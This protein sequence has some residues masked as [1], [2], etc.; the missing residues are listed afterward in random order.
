MNKKIKWKTIVVKTDLIDPSP[1]NYK[2]ANKLGAERLKQSLK[3]FGLAGSVI[4]NPGKK[5]RYV[6]ID[7]NSRLLEAKEDGEKTLNVSIPNRLLTPKEFL[8]M[9]K[10]YDLSKAG[11]VDEARIANDPGT[12][13]DFFKNYNMPIPASRLNAL[14]KGSRVVLDAKGDLAK[15]KKGKESI[16]LR[17][18]FIEPPFSVLDTKQGSWQDRK[19]EWLEWGVVGELGREGDLV[20]IESRDGRQVS[21]KKLTTGI[22]MK[23]YEDMGEYY[24]EEAQQLNTSIFDPALCELMYS[25]FVPKAGNV[26]DPFAGGPSRGLVAQYLG[27]KYYGIELSRRQVNANVEQAKKLLKSNNQPTYY[28]GDSDKL[29]GK[30]WTQRFDFIFSCP[31]YFNLEVYSKDPNDLSAMNYESFQSTLSSIV[32]KSCDLLKPKRYAAF[33]ISPVRDKKTGYYLDLVGDVVKA[34]TDAGLVFYNDAVLLNMIGSASM[35]ADKQF[36]ASKKL[37]RVHQNVLIFYK[38]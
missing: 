21:K 34:F 16:L 37:V 26:L 1:T 3:E 27:F 13:N 30:K 31:P 28:Q 5:G 23:K 11:D 19:R 12:T 15:D 29:L 24:S 14:G 10:V 7:G 33:V 17:D 32:E 9:C 22:P 38:P 4:C 18:K 8:K 36:T 6:L 25:W 20:A 2:I 35:R